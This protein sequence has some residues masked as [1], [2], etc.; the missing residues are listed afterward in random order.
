MILTVAFYQH[1]TGNE[2]VRD[3]LVS[4]LRDDRKIIGFDIK[5]VQL[6][7]P[8]GMPLVKSMGDGLWE[9]RSHLTGSKIARVLFF[10]D[11]HCMILVHGFIKKTQKTPMEDIELAKKRKKRYEQAKR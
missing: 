8:L 3:W 11:G 4:L 7:W 6:G 9:V 5:T 10:L 2:P 1:E